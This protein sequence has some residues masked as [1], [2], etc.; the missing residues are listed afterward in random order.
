MVKNHP[1][2]FSSFY[3]LF[4]FSL[5][6]LINN[7]GKENTLP[8]FF[9]FFNIILISILKLQLPLKDTRHVIS[10]K[11]GSS[12]G[13]EMVSVDWLSLEKFGESKGLQDIC[14]GMRLIVG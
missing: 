3:P 13:H 2:L 12:S 10:L 14:L 5:P 8:L 7:W 4:P 11:M 9:L 6:S 1:S